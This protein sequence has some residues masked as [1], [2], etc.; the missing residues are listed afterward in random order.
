MHTV[1]SNEIRGADLYF[2]A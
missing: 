1:I 2:C